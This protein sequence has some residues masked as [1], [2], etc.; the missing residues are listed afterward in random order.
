MLRRSELGNSGFGFGFAEQP[1]PHWN[2]G[3]NTGDRYSFVVV[4]DGESKGILLRRPKRIVHQ[5]PLPRKLPREVFAHVVLAHCSRQIGE[6]SQRLGS[7]TALV[8]FSLDRKQRAS[9]D[10]SLAYAEILG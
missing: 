2:G 4:V 6:S 7:Q 9:F 8:E 3:E 5:T 1:K 10:P